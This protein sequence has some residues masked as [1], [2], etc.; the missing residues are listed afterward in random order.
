MAVDGWETSDPSTMRCKAQGSQTGLGE[1]IQDPPHD[2]DR[3]Q[4][5]KGEGKQGP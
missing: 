2:A 5:G 3:Y 4:I 1:K